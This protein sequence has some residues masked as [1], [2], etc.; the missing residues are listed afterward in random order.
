[1]TDLSPDNFELT[2]LEDKFRRMGLKGIKNGEDQ[3]EW[4]DLLTEV[5]LKENVEGLEWRIEM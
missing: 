2:Q 4:V 1:M 5:S 3:D